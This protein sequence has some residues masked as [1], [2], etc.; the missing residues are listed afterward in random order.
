[1]AS[2]E[3]IFEK[4][5]FIARDSIPDI[6]ISEIE[7]VVG[8]LFPP[9]YKDFL[10]KFKQNEGTLGPEYVQ[11]WNIEDLIA[12]N[13]D[14]NILDNLESTIGIGTNLGG[15]LIAIENFG[16]DLYRVVLSPFIDL[17]K[18]YHN[19]IGDSFSDFLVR[20]DNGIAWFS[21]S[22]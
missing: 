9:D 11:L 21:D 10:L 2:I 12:T 3:L 6:L 18:N 17:D 14:Y 4:Y 13:R 19:Q 20:L 1:M 7:S 5:K 15:E 22:N 16:H 8:F